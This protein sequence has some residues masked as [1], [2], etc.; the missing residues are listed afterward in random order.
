MGVDILVFGGQLDGFL[1]RLE[2]V[3]LVGFAHGVA[4]AIVG[5]ADAGAGYEVVLAG[6]EAGDF[7]LEVGEVEHGCS[8]PYCAEYEG[9]VVFP[10]VCVHVGVEPF[11]EPT[12]F[13][14]F[15]VLDHQAV[16]VA[17]V[18][19]A[20]HT[21]PCNILTVRRIGRVGVVACVGGSD[22]LVQ[23]GIKVVEVDVGV[24]G[25]GIVEACF[26]AAG[27]GYLLPVGTPCELLNTAKGFHGT[28]VGCA[29]ENVHDIAD[30]QLS[31]IV[32]EVAQEGVRCCFRPLVPVLVHEV[33]HHAPRGKRQVGVLVRGGGYGLD[34]RDEDDFVAFGREQ[35]AF[36][37]AVEAL[38]AQFVGV[39]H[40]RGEVEF[41][42]TEIRHLRVAP[43]CGAVAY[44]L[45]VGLEVVVGLFGEAHPRGGAVLG[46]AVVTDGVENVACFG[47]G[48]DVADTPHRPEGFGCETTA[49]N[50][51]LRLGDGRQVV[52]LF[53]VAGGCQ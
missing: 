37:V 36:D 45:L 51:D 5:V 52:R 38:Q 14:C 35:E 49:F 18:A 26:L 25:D 41:A 47:V 39:G 28:L 43:P 30:Y 15:E 33:V 3:N 34:L 27:V 24:G 6:G 31:A 12:H 4:H 17:L 13:T 21:E 46:D 10:V 50:G 11:G 48:H 42:A 23:F 16:L 2:T 22:V 32:A 8:V 1:S 9:V 7:A 20:C 19:V 44:E 53:L 40:P 29:V